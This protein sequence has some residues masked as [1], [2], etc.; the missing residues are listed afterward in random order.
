MTTDPATSFSTHLR[1]RHTA[2][3]AEQWGRRW[4]TCDTSRVATTLANNASW[5]P[6]STTQTRP[7]R[8]SVGSGFDYRKAPHVT[9]KSIANTNRRA[10]NTVRPTAC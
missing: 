10:K 1:L 5:A 2:Y 7:P 6:P 8:R 3:V 9:L 4:I